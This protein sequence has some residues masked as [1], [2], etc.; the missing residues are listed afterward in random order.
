MVAA[1]SAV[2]TCAGGCHGAG[3]GSATD[4]ST[5]GASAGISGAAMAPAARSASV[6]SE[7]AGGAGGAAAD[8][9]GAGAFHGGGAADSIGL[10][11]SGIGGGG[12]GGAEGAPHDGAGGAAGSSVFGMSHAG[13]AAWFHAGA[14]GAAADGPAGAS[15]D[16]ATV[17]G[18]REQG[19]AV[20]EQHP[21]REEGST[22]ATRV[23]SMTAPKGSRGLAARRSAAPALPMPGP[24]RGAH[25]MTVRRTL[26]TVAWRPE[27]RMARPT[28]DPEQRLAE[29]RGPVAALVRANPTSELRSVQLR[30]AGRPTSASSTLQAW[31]RRAMQEP[32]IRNREA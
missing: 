10:G 19:P 30:A 18:F 11:G 31:R 29:S 3:A 5:G 13:A 16:G 14:G 24:G 8:Q 32:P 25:P 17:G 4:G 28:M 27:A 7:T 6:D 2:P 15:H 23:D 1:T 21:R 20:R 22:R 9:T 12:A 26:R